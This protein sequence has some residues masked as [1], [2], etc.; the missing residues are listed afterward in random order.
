MSK[1]AEVEIVPYRDGPYLVRG[2]VVVRDQEGRTIAL[3]RQPVALCRCGKSR[4]RPFCDGT[5]QLIRFQAPSQPERPFPAAAPKPLSAPAAG[6]ASES[7]GARSR[8]DLD[9]D[10]TAAAQSSLDQAA[11]LVARTLEALGR[12]AG[13]ARDDPQ[14]SAA[15][16]SLR[17]AARELGRRV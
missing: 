15:M 12:A 5:H 11:R 7:E 3:P 17:D 13:P 10:A 16:A 6:S 8:S 9:G 2:P 1:R 4:I 14:L